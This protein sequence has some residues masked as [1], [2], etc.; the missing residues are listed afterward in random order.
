MEKVWLRE[1][2]FWNSPY[3]H[4]DAFNISG[5]SGGEAAAVVFRRDTADPVVDVGHD[6]DVVTEMPPVR[7]VQGPMGVRIEG[8]IGR[9]LHIS[10]WNDKKK[11]IMK[12]RLLIS[13]WKLTGFCVY[14]VILC[15][16]IA[17]EAYVTR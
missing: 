14:C 1:I 2:Y 13:I 16:R 5:R 8:H 12:T 9:N 10:V 17:L 6:Q 15:M 7:I 3:V 11:L 4:N